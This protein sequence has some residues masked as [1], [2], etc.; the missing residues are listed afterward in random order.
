MEITLVQ[1][2]I[3]D[4]LLQNPY[5]GRVEI[6]TYLGNI[7]EDGVKYN[8]KVLQQKGV[9]KRIGP[10]KGGHWDIITPNEQG[11]IDDSK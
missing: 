6:A 11:I 4:Y 8:L 2:G 10:D 3:V 9:L 5:A 1:K 7:S